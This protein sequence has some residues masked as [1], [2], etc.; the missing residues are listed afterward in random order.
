MIMDNPQMQE[1]KNLF[2][3]FLKHM[4]NHFYFYLLFLLKI[5]KHFYLGFGSHTETHFFF[6]LF[7]SYFYI[8]LYKR[9]SIKKYFIKEVG[10]KV[11]KV[12]KIVV[13]TRH[14]KYNINSDRKIISNFFN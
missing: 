1:N 7:L 5:H 14:E 4:K 11:V 3:V 13:L 12:V 2:F 10:I 6:L 8:F 9:V